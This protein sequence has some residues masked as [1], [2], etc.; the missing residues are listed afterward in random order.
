M[1]GKTL[2]VLDVILNLAILLAIGF[3]VDAYWPA[4]YQGAVISTSAHSGASGV[5]INDHQIITA[6]HVLGDDA[7]IGGWYGGILT[8][9]DGEKSA[10]T[11]TA[12]SEGWDL[13]II[14]TSTLPKAPT[15]SLDCTD[16]L[17]IGDP[18]TVMGN[19]MGLGLVTTW[20]KVAKLT[21]YQVNGPG[22]AFGTGFLID[23]TIL[24]GNSGGP[25]YN[26]RGQVI[27]FSDSMVLDSGGD[28]F[29]LTFV[30]PAYAAC[31]MLKD[32]TDHAN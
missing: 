11:I 28:V 13:A 14:T 31:N 22:A 16:D 18:V 23:A 17:A 8:D 3:Q 27:G 10:G 12:I 1:L 26:S 7:K 30:E 21:G 9:A 29:P 15:A 4:T 24:P 6:A 19:P 2:L 25:V 20:G 32:L 5:R